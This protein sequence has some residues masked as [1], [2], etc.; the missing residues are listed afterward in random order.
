MNGRSGARSLPSCN[1]AHWGILDCATS[2]LLYVASYSRAVL[3]SV[4][5]LQAVLTGLTNL[6]LFNVGSNQLTGTIP[7]L[8]GLTNLV[9][10]SAYYN[11]LTGT[12]SSLTGLANLYYF[13]AGFNQ[14]TGPIP[15]LAGLKNLGIFDVYSNQL[16]GTFPDLTGL[17]GLGYFRVGAN[18][19]SGALPVAPSG[20]A[21]EGSS[22]CPNDFPESTYIDAPAWDTATGFTPW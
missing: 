19:L 15:S 21:A 14:L 8:E 12:I 11:Q 13:D 4:P 20:L 17:T 16:T 7:S 5:A 1:V 9:E 22:L 18:H 10:F 6:S 2:S 3:D